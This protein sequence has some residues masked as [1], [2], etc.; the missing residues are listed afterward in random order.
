MTHTTNPL[1]TSKTIEDALNQYNDAKRE[2][3]A[4]SLFGV[5]KYQTRFYAADGKALNHD[6]NNL[7]RTQDLEPWYE[8]NSC[9]YIFDKDLLGEP[10]R[11]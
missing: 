10:V 7:I 11:E 4:D 5:T 3:N 6:P 1:L 9:I 8:E 2:D